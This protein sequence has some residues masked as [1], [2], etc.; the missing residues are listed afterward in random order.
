[1][2]WLKKK[3]IHN[4]I[5]IEEY[6]HLFQILKMYNPECIEDTIIVSKGM[7][8]IEIIYPLSC[9]TLYWH[10]IWLL[11]PFLFCVNS[12]IVW[13]FWWILK[14]EVDLNS[15]SIFIF[16]LGKPGHVTGHVTNNYCN[17][18]QSTFKS[19]KDGIRAIVLYHVIYGYMSQLAYNRILVVLFLRIYSAT[20]MNIWTEIS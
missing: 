13:F 16:V 12:L 8:R 1:M 10:R 3:R 7:V 20:D 6:Q 17:Q 9:C 14:F 5:L 18:I 2:M 4:K 19:Y 15:N 11:Y